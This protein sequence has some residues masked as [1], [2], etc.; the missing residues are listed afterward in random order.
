MKPGLNDFPP[1]MTLD[2]TS[3]RERLADVAARGLAA[4]AAL[5]TAVLMMSAS[6]EWLM[7]REQAALAPGR[8][9]LGLIFAVVASGTALLTYAR[10]PRGATAFCLAGATAA[11]AWHSWYTGLGVYSSALAGVGILIA[12]AGMLLGLRVAA[13]LTAAYAVMVWALAAADG[14]GAIDSRQAL[15]AMAPFN[16]ILGLALLGAGGLMAAALMHRLITSSLLGA[17]SEQER[18]AELLHI[19]SDWSWEMDARAQLTYLSPT[20]EARTGR[21]VVEFLRLAQDG[22]PTIVADAEWDRLLVELRAMRPYRDRVITFR[23]H[24][25]TLLAVRGNGDPIHDR[26]G[27]FVGWRGVSRNVTAERLAQREQQRTQAMLDRMVQTSPDAI[28]VARSNGTLLMVNHGYAAL[29]GLPETQL[30]GKTA[31][32]LGIL[33]QQESLRLRDAIAVDGVVRDFRTTVSRAGQPPREVAVSAGTFEWDG[34]VAAVITTRDITDVERARLEAD[35]ILDN[36]SVGIALVRQG[37]FERVNPVFETM[38]GR[39]V[40]S[41]ADHNGSVMF[42]DDTHFTTFA[43]RAHS[44]LEQGQAIDLERP[45]TR[46][47]GRLMQVRLRARGVDPARLAEGGVI[48]VA[49]DVT[50]RRRVE[51]ELALA[52]QQAEA[53][54]QAKSAFLATMSHEIR[55]P[56][57]GVLGLAQLLRDD[58]L[59]RQRRTE[60]LGHLVDAAQQLASI[61]S[62]V[63]DLSKIEAGHLALEDI[64]LDLHEVVMSTFHTFAPLGR[65]RG[66]QMQCDIDAAVP[67]RLR[68]DP[69][70]L[71]QILANFLSNALKFTA[72]GAIHLRVMPGPGGRTRLTVSDSGPGVTPELRKRLFRPFVQA[73]GSTTRR[74]GGTGLGLSIC[75]ELATRMG[76]EVGVDSDGR[77]GSTFWAELLLARDAPGTHE[78]PA[79]QG[80]YPLAGLQVLVAE[81]NAVNML[82]VCAMLERLGATPWQADNGAKALM[83]ARDHAGTLQAVLMDLHMPLVDGLEATRQLQADTRT[84][85][86]PVFALSAATLENER[87]A[88]RAAGMQGF[89]AKPVLEAEL[90]RVLLPYVKAE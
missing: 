4:M 51:R 17:L 35:A 80:A 52:K 85:H 56:L 19:G 60:Y 42:D 12:V 14:Q 28:C 84:D 1:G 64:P 7:L 38:F 21:K 54:N 27:R 59:E 5:L 61:V 77:H 81:D 78:M 48:W 65:E 70:R 46:P 37:R 44:A 71:R 55:T 39:T 66:L 86:L 47:D 76:G 58:T 24:D 82:I 32:E 25:G 57:N 10:Y 83:M 69:V 79:A 63:L 72:Q 6:A 40:G 3:V 29:V 15:L 20:F 2:A 89:I 8:F 36:A 26:Q 33:G 75:R 22:G 16:Q 41:L 43:E 31:V 45:F 11:V 62:D 9:R 67:Q 90:L 23:C 13:W 49:E 73:D 74:F 53:A 30:L 88:A 18:L 50:E 87:D 34:E 68:G